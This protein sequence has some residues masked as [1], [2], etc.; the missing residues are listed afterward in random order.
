SQLL[1]LPACRVIYCLMWSGVTECVVLSS[2][3]GSRMLTRLCAL[4]SECLVLTALRRLSNRLMLAALE[5][6]TALLSYCRM[7]TARRRIL[8]RCRGRIRATLTGLHLRCLTGASLRFER[9]C[10]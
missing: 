3:T 10:R 8:L 4:L 1:I 9:R 7:L 6:L 2:L 5:G